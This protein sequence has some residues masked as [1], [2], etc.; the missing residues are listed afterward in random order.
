MLDR[1]ASGMARITS[2]LEVIVRFISIILL[3]VLICAVFFQVARRTIT[4]KSFIELEEFSIVMAAWCAFFTIAYSV[5]K[6]SHVMIDVFTNKLPFHPRHILTLVINTTIFVAT[7]VLTN[8]GWALG[9]RKMLVPM[10]VLP[11]KSGLWYIALPIGM[12]FACIFL[13]DNV[14]QELVLLRR[15]ISEKSN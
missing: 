15:G 3:I 14:I 8:A 1:I 9:M 7:V 11:F 12:F 5:R 13:L 4:G 2:K 6:K 10:T